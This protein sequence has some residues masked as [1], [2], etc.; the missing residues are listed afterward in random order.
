VVALPDGQ[1]WA[2]GFYY[3]GTQGRT[4][5]IHGDESGFVTA[6]GEDFSGE[7]NVLL[8]IAAVGPSDIWAAGYHYPSGTSDYQGLTEHYDGKQWKRASSAQ[9]ES[10]TYL[11]GI[12][13]W[14]PGA[15]WAVGNTLTATIAESV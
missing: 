1:I 4:L 13:A 14:T 9:G 10:Y 2:A 7:G 8:G 11:A 12:T 3:D 6:P 5:F 15:A